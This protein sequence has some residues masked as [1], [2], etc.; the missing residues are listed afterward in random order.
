MR[1]FAALSHCCAFDSKC[2]GDRPLRGHCNG[3]VA[4]SPLFRHIGC[5]ER[6]TL[7]AGV[8]A[9]C[10]SDRARRRPES[11]GIFAFVRLI[12]L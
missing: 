10:K 1:L 4:C 6:L 11:A 2:G 5:N 3:A 12:A 9:D 8:G 7:R